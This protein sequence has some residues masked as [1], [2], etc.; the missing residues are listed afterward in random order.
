MRTHC[1]L[2]LGAALFG[3]LSV[4]AF[5]DFVTTQ[6]GSNVNLDVSRIASY[7]PAG[8]GFIG[9]GVI[10]KRHNRI[11]GLTTAASLW[12]A[13][14]VGLGAGLGSWEAAV[15]TTVIALAGLL[16]DR[17]IGALMRR[18]RGAGSVLHITVEREDATDTIGRLCDM[19]GPQGRVTS[20]ERAEDGSIVVALHTGPR[21]P[22]DVSRVLVHVAALPGVRAVE[23]DQK[24]PDPGG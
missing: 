8:V 6:A 3:L 4:S 17:P 20:V 7:I 23:Q 14:A 19:A 11:R 5:A 9:A 24:T 15:V 21:P 10:L 18:I 12:V 16:S 1:L 2:A 13:A 22:A